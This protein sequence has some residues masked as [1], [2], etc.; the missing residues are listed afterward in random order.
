MRITQTPPTFRRLSALSAFDGPNR[1]FVVNTD[2][3]AAG[4]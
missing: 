3:P 2:E 1:M 4:F